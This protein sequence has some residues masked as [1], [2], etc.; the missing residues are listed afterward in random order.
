MTIMWKTDVWNQILGLSAHMEGQLFSCGTAFL[1]GKRLAMTATHVLDQPFNRRHFDQDAPGADEFGVLACQIIER[2]E[3]PLLW[4]V[5]QMGR[6]PSLSKRDDRPFDI[7][8]LALEPFGSVEQK[9]EHHRDRFLELNVATPKI[10]MKVVGY[11]FTNPR[12]DQDPTDIDTSNLRCQFR[13]IEGTVVNVH[14]PK[15]DEVGM[16]FPCF[17]VDADFEPGMSGGP[18]F[19]DR[20]QVCGV[21]SRGSGFGASWGSILW[22]ALAIQV[23]GMTGLELAHKGEILARNFHCVKLH[24]APGEK[25]PDVSFDPNKEI[26]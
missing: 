8:L 16:P 3:T 12:W 5:K 6:Y 17:Q 19:N 14:F 10:G 18:I 11:G 25:F 15:R 1:I 2:R 9:I 7:G 23:N 22:P 24:Q 21:I 20:Q 4:Q 13:R 26:L